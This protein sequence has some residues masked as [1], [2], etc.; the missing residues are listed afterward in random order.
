MQNNVPSFWSDVRVDYLKTMW[1]AGRSGG[2]IA[3]SL[4]VTRCS[5]L[6][7]IFRLRLPVRAIENNRR[8]KKRTPEQIAAKRAKDKRG[9]EKRRAKQSAVKPQ[10]LTIT[11]LEALRCVEVEPLGKTLLELGPNECRYPYGDGPYTF[12]GNPTMGECSYCGP[13]F[14]VTARRGQT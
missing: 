13:H 4:G 8:Y 3:S 6:G 5:V 2:E 12:C 11:N 7:K 9:N 1:S 10:K 14:G